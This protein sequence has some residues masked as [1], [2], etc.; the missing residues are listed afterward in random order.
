MTIPPGFVA[1]TLAK[2]C[3]CIMPERVYVADLRLEEQIRREAASQGWCPRKP[4]ARRG[5]PRRASPGMS[6]SGGR[7]GGDLPRRGRPPAMC[8]GGV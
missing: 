4:H 8:A 6:S 5:D 3:L 1:L 2:G 7:W